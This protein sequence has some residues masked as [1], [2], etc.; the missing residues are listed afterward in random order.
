MYAIVN[1]S[2][3]QFKAEKGSKLCVPKLS[4]EEGK[5][6]V[7]SL[8]RVDFVD[9]QRNIDD[10]NAARSNRLS[11]AFATYYRR[12][13]EQAELAEEAVAIIEQNNEN[14]NTES[15]VIIGNS[16]YGKAAFV[17]RRHKQEEKF[18]IWDPKTGDPYFYDLKQYSSKFLFITT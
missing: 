12:N 2:G 10:E 13:L 14:Y 1:I 3:K 11:D 7:H 17:F 6:I 4:L 9:A 18:E 8:L 5:K 16:I 15:F